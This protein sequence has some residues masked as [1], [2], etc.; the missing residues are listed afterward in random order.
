[1]NAP[2]GSLAQSAKREFLSFRIGEQ[3]YCVDI[4]AVREIRGWSRPTPL[5]HAEDHIRGVINLRGTVILIVD[6]ARRLGIAQ[7][8][9]NA[10]NVIIVSRI[11]NQTVGLMVDAVSDILAVPEA[12]IQPPPDVMSAQE[13]ALVKSLMIVD[14]RMLRVLDLEV[15]LPD[16]LRGAA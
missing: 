3:E 1:M 15:V 9:D 7:R 4:M 5:P 10:R 11:R 13:C 16:H 2:S 6:L 8:E 14:D 12:D